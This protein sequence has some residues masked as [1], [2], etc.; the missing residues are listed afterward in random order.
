[1]NKK[2]FA[3]S[4]ER[5][6]K[7]LSFECTVRKEKKKSYLQHSESR[8]KSQWMLTKKITLY[9]GKY[10]NKVTVVHK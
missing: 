3:L 8:G 6:E 1:M 4:L 2:I 9:V 5:R 7:Y 10:K